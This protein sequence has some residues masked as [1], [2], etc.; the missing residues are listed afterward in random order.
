VPGPSSPAIDVPAY[1]EPPRRPRRPR[2]GWALLAV[3]VVL[4]AAIG[5]WLHNLAT[6]PPPAA[7]SGPSL[8]I[9]DIPLEAVAPGSA[10]PSAP[11]QV[12]VAVPGP[13]D[14]RAKW[15]SNLAYQ[16]YL[17][18]PALRAYLAAEA[19]LAVRAPSCHLSW[20]TLAGV[21]WVESR[22]G[23]YQGNSIGPDGRETTP[24]IGPALDGSPGRQRVP[25]T[26][27]GLL[28]GDPIW[29]HAL[30]PMQFLPQT[31]QQW[32]LRAG[33]DGQAPDPQNINDAALTA[34]NYLCGTGGDLSQP[35]NWW[36]AVFVYNNSTSY[37][38]QVFSAADAY[39]RATL[40]TPTPTPAPATP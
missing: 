19:D 6:P 38:Q 26:D 9:F 35:A 15:I 5:V 18:E 20:T 3:L 8:P 32:G 22:H 27:H 7:Y 4:F 24:I 16:T 11:G 25:D 21:G 12:P 10:I 23:Q 37:G 2:L 28:D 13:A 1:P 34:A 17:P 33:G 36:S 29:D 39:A 30:G 31:W 14:P 40:P